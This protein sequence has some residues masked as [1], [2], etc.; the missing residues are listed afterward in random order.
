MVDIDDLDKEKSKSK[1]SS[2]SGSS[3]GGSGGGGSSTSK[4]GGTTT[5]TGPTEPFS[6]DEE[7][8]MDAEGKSVSHVSK[9][10]ASDKGEMNY[11]A[12]NG[13]SLKDYMKRQVKEVEELHDNIHD[14]AMDNKENFD[15]FTLFMHALFMNF[16]R[17][18]VGIM[19]TIQENFGKTEQEAYELTNKICDKAGEQEFMEQ[20]VR[21]MTRDLAEM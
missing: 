17:N 3:G 16:G 2:S 12:H 11:D 1:G 14:M 7:E 21:D 13:E 6:V 20:M 4:S 19:E 18:R 5:S 8:M 15:E 9:E 10:W